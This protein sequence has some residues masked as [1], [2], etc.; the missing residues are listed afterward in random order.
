MAK[1][2]ARSLRNYQ[3]LLSTENHAVLSD[4]PRGVGDGLGP[5]PY[6]LLLAA[7][8]SC[9]TMTVEMYARRKQW[10]LEGVEATITH[11]RVH[12]EDCA[13]C[14]AETG[15]VDRIGVTLRFRGDLSEE[16]TARLREIATRCPVRRTL[17]G[18]INV[19]DKVE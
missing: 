1:V 5:N 12:A 13:A 7:L 3:I 6:E 10:P 11:D 19:I 18:A 16:Q 15:I 4:E 2:E 14:E 9:T 8:G 17:T